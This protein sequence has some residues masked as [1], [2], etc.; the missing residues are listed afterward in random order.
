MYGERPV[1]LLHNH[2]ISFSMNK[3]LRFLIGTGGLCLGALSAW[4][5][6]QEVT[7]TVTDASDD[8]TLPGVNVVV[9]GSTIGTVTD[10]DGNYR[11]NASDGTAVLVFS[12]VGFKTVEVPVDN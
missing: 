2:L 11:I 4:A 10:I 6:A 7:G 12:S 3:F 8:S 1:V 9:K 5:Q